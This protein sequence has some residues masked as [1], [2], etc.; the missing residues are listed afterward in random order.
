ML[1]RLSRSNIMRTLSSKK[2]PLGRTS[3]R[4]TPRSAAQRWCHEGLR[5]GK[6]MSAAPCASQNKGSDGGGCTWNMGYESAG[7][8]YCAPGG[9]KVCTPLFDV[10][11]SSHRGHS[12]LPYSESTNLL[13]V[14]RGHS[15]WNEI[16][17]SGAC[18]MMRVRS[19]HHHEGF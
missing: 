3:K 13:G 10:V 19:G 15:I 14:R 6:Y 5:L 8:Y 1:L 2:W 4:I 18:S 16:P 11:M 17:M 9:K 7:H 12:A